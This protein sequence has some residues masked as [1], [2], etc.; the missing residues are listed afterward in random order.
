MHDYQV[1]TVRFNLAFKVGALT[2]SSSAPVTGTILAQY[3]EAR[4]AALKIHF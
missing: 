3:F 4:H 1:I 2:L